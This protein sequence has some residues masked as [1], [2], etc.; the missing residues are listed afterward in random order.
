MIIFKLLSILRVIVSN[1]EPR[2]D[3][4]KK[5]KAARWPLQE[6]VYIKRGFFIMFIRYPANVTAKLQNYYETIIFSLSLRL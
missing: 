4:T 2:H 1:V 3:G 5:K 6:K